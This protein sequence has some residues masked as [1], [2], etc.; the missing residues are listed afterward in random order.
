MNQER[1]ERFQRAISDERLEEA[2]QLPARKLPWRR[3]GMAATCVCAAAT[4][5]IWAGRGYLRPE[6]EASVDSQE[7]DVQI[8]SPIREVTREEL[9][10]LGYEMPVPEE[11]QELQY[12]LI[13]GGS[14]EEALAEVMFTLDGCA[15]TYRSQKTGAYQDISGMYYENKESSSWSEENLEMELC[16]TGDEAWFGWFDQKEGIQ[17]SLSGAKS[18]EE[19]LAVSGR[20]AQLA[21]QELPLQ[22]FSDGE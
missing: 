14:G 10:E 13:D 12:I 8:A 16:Q 19:A 21:G 22:A 7:E 2:Q 18:G 4:V 1:F 6:Q 3:F 5:L 20:L 11:A 15:Y 9:A 17:R